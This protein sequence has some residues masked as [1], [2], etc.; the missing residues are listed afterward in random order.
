MGGMDRG[1]VK[2]L[3]ITGVDFNMH[4]DALQACYC[5]GYSAWDVVCIFKE[6]I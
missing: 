4:Y 5:V 2:E 6:N 1:N 3:V